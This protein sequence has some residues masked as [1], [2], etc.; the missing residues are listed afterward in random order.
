MDGAAKTGIPLVRSM[1]FEFPSWQGS[2][3]I[4]TQA[5]LG[6]QVLIAPVLIRKATVVN[7]SIPPGTSWTH[8]SSGMTLNE[9]GE[10]HATMGDP[11]VFYKNPTDPMWL[12][13]WTE[14]G[15]L[16]SNVA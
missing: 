12:N 14:V 3:N 2:E 1:W 15:A 6:S 11:A 4:E 7:V 8:M 5:M 13:L 16:L 9:T 10:V